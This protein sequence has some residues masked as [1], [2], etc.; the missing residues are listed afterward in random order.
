MKLKAFN[1]L[2]SQKDIKDMVKLI[3]DY[4]FP[5]F[6]RESLNIDI[7]KKRI[8]KLYIKIVANDFFLLDFMEQ[9]DDITLSLEKDLEFFFESD[10]A[11]KSYDE[12]V[13]T[14]PG[15]RAIFHYRIAHIFYKQ[16][17]YL[18]ART[19]SEFAHSKTGIDIHPGAVIG[20]SFFIDHGTGIVIGET[21]II[22]HN[23]KIY[24]GVTLGALSLTD[25]RSLEG[26]KRHPT[27]CNYVTIY[28]NASIF[29]GNTVIGENTVIGANCIVLESVGENEKVLFNENMS[30]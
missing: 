1:E 8:E 10:P 4:I 13:L 3:R 18:I 22:G 24:Q 2:P 16:K 9:I 7:L 11:S 5:N 28:A 15:F 19:I 21:T 23:V 20:D 14:Y 27:V 6:F 29:G 30:V 25:G 12:I 26:Q 17:E